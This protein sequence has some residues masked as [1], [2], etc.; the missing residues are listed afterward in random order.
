MRNSTVTRKIASRPIHFGLRT[1][2]H[3][4][5][6]RCAAPPVAL[7]LAP[8]EPPQAGASQPPSETRAS[9]LAGATM[10][11]FADIVF[12]RA[13]SALQNL[14]QKETPSLSL[15][16]R[17]FG[18]AETPETEP[19]TISNFHRISFHIVRVSSM[20]AILHTRT[21]SNRYRISIEF[22]RTQILRR[23]LG[24]PLRI[25]GIRPNSSV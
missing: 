17:S 3:P 20:L 25:T 14:F 18:S 22:T 4:V 12:C 24:S 6:T 5:M 13:K 16:L 23:Q 9:E 15:R 21:P 10:S 1:Y 2:C 11:A 8:E 7:S 19:R